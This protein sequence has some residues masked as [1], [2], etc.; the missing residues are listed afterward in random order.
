MDIAFRLVRLRGLGVPATNRDAFDLLSGAGM[1]D[2]DLAEALK[3]MVG[4][5]NVAVHRYTDLEVAIVERVIRFGLDDL[6][7]FVAIALRL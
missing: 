7:A 6:A 3:R 1:I 2:R 5:R 4:F